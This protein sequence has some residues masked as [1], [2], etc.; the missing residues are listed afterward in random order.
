[1]KDLILWRHAEAEIGDINSSIEDDLSRQLTP[2][3]KRQAKR[4]ANWLRQQ[5]VD[6]FYLITSPAQRALQTAAYLD[7]TM[8]VDDALR[9]STSLDEVLSALSQL[10][11]TQQQVIIV[12]HQPWLGELVAHFTQSGHTQTPIKKGATW[13]LRLSPQSSSS[14]AAYAVFSVQTPS[15]LR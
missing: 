5:Q 15:L 4:M 1:M 6:H 9:P 14:Q 7:S 13:W 8:R 10:Q 12:G 11:P 2:K 3:G